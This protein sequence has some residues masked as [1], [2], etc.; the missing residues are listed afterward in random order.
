MSRPDPSAGTDLQSSV[1]ALGL[2][3]LLAGAGEIR[4]YLVGGAVRDLLLGKARTDVDVA[5]EGDAIDL[6]DRVGSKIRAHERFGTATVRLG[7]VTVDLARTRSE[8][9][10]RPGALPEVRPASIDADLARRDFTINAMA[11]PLDQPGHLLDPH[12][13]REDLGSGRLRVLH[14]RSFEDDPT[15]A[16]RAARYA[17]RLGFELEAG[18]ERALREVDLGTVSTERVEA[19]LLRLLT[20][21]E[22]RRGFELLAD[23]G[24][25]R[26]ADLDRMEAVRALLAHE[27]WAAVAAR[28][29]TVLAAG[30]PTAG[31]YSP[32]PDPLYQARE[33]AATTATH[34]SALATLARASSPQALVIARALGA[35]WLDSYLREWRHVR[36][37]I[38][39]DDLIDAGIPRGPAI[40]R[41]LTAA[42][43]AKLDGHLGGREE[44]LRAAL[45]AAANVCPDAE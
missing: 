27:P 11:L 21:T 10:P 8:T 25:A 35:E 6:A 44:E 17:A 13:G 26:G 4:L 29:Q 20:E 45:E 32:P 2:D 22:W 7:E 23:W 36:L 24:V 39:G 18:T 41:G 34:P 38:D 33:L 12:G 1:A 37:E 30:G 19:E 40:G 9:Y 3:P 16:L 5:V 15:R 28:G 42:L 43:E 14:E 31:T